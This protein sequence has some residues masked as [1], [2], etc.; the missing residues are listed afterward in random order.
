MTGMVQVGNRRGAVCGAIPCV[1]L[2][3]PVNQGKSSLLK[4]G[5]AKKFHGRE[6][7]QMD[8]YALNPLYPPFS[9]VQF[10]LRVLT[11]FYIW[12]NAR[13]AKKIQSFPSE[14]LPILAIVQPVLTNPNGI[15]SFSPGLR[16]Y[17]G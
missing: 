17:P 13:P 12:Q 14:S 6:R 1:L 9:T 8:V 3:K 10:F 4:P 15:Q 7:T 11:R 5:K 16:S 2:A